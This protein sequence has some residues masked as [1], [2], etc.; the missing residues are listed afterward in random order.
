MVDLTER[1]RA[2][3]CE[4]EQLLHVLTCIEGCGLRSNTNRFK[5]Y[6]AAAGMRTVMIDV[7]TARKMRFS[8]T[9]SFSTVNN[10]C[11]LDF[12]P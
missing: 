11:I 1:G 2:C 6:A 9:L 8:V 5:I 4:F 3:S 12:I 10:S 7:R